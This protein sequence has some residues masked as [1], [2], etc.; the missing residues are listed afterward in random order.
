MKYLTVILVSGLALISLVG[1]QSSEEPN[2][3]PSVGTI[4]DNWPQAVSSANQS[5][6]SSPACDPT[7]KACDTSVYHSNGDSAS[8]ADDDS[9]H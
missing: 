6:P 7:S 5:Q 8:S 1:C 4:G 9:K 2:P 3:N